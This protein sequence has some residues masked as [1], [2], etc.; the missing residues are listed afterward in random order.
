MNKLLSSL[1]NK[2]HTNY[3]SSSFLYS[4]KEAIEL[5][6]E[7][8]TLIDKANRYELLSTAQETLINKSE[9]GVKCN[10]CPFVSQC[11]FK[12]VTDDCQ[13]RMANKGRMEV[14]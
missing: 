12:V 10:Y 3:T 13:V 2:I 5:I 8:K 4:R 11:I 7:I 9:I 14:L 1:E 6:E